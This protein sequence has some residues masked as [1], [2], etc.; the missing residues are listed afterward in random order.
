[1]K[2]FYKNFNFMTIENYS[3]EKLEEHVLRLLDIAAE[4]HGIAKQMRQ[5]NLD[6]IPLNDKKAIL[7]LDA[8]EA[9]AIRSKSKAE[10][11]IRKAFAKK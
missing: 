7:L 9:W 10:I 8:L 2:K 3:P 5:N 6:S 1:M 4:I 11:H